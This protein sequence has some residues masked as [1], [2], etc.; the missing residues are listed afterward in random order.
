MLDDVLA[1]GT[2][3]FADTPFISAEPVDSSSTSASSFSSWRLKIG[4]KNQPRSIECAHLINAA[5]LY[6]DK[7]AHQFGFAQDYTVRFA[8]IGVV[9]INS[10]HIYA[11]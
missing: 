2:A 9:D 11:T 5:G 1:S 3:V 6:A 10:M 7:V 4:T 8:E